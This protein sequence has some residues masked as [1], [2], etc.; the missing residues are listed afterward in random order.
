MIG[1]GNISTQAPQGPPKLP[2]FNKADP[3]GGPQGPPPQASGMN[4]QSGIP[5]RN[6]APYSGPPVGPQQQG[7]VNPQRNMNIGERSL[8]QD[9]TTPL[10][11]DIGNMG[12]AMANMIDR[13]T[14]PMTPYPWINQVNAMGKGMLA[15]SVDGFMK[16]ILMPMSSPLGL[17]TSVAGPMGGAIRGANA[18]RLATQ[19]EPAAAEA[20]M[21]MGRMGTQMP[22]QAQALN[23]AAQGLFKQIPGKVTQKLTPQELQ[24]I[25][26]AARTPRR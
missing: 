21:A 1:M 8:W 16:N 11:P 20:M 18:A 4:P 15:G 10:L 9:L 3:R 25:L 22:G 26:A 19:V 14:N 12:G 23:Q 24:T 7:Q 13:P 5:M 17:A 6:A 2:M